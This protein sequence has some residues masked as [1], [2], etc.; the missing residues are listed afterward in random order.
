MANAITLWNGSNILRG[1]NMEKESWF[2]K[3]LRWLGLI[4]PYEISK[5]EMC[6]RAKSVCSGKCSECAWNGD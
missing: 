4:K 5:S 3:L 2:Y 1:K 6:E